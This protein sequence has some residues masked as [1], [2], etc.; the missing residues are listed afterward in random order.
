MY[1]TIGW[2]GN[3]IVGCRFWKFSYQELSQFFFSLL[4]ASV[5]P[6]IIFVTSI[7]QKKEVNFLI[8]NG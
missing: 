3:K 4:I 6:S 2:I 8:S 1:N 5:I 7:T